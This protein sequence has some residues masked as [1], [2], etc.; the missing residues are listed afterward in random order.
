[1]ADQLLR[2]RSA[3]CTVKWKNASWGV[4]MMWMPSTRLV[5]YPIRSVLNLA[6]NS[7]WLTSDG[8]GR[9]D[10]ARLLQALFWLTYASGCI[11][12]HALDCVVIHVAVA[13]MDVLC[14][15]DIRFLRPVLGKWPESDVVNALVEPSC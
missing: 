1:M 14:R 2:V 8:N 9:P 10:P 4:L 7:S 6:I 12:T 11:Y 3:A 15:G 13:Q 5:S